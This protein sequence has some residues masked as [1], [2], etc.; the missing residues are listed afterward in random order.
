MTI[1]AA[2]IMTTP[3]ASVAPEATIAEV[4]S[5]L[6]S[7]RISAVPVCNPDG[8]MAG[9]VSES[10]ILKPFR[11]S[12][13]ARRDWWLGAVAE[14]EELHQDFLDYLRQDTRAAADVM[15]RH[16]IAVEEDATLPRLAELMIKHG[17]KRLPVLRDGRLV[18]IVSRSDLVAAVAKAPGMLV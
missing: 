10:D 3:V 4:A 5:L 8:S 7:K 6:A 1:T 16:V 12:A 11:E 14:G 18:G 13:R 9:I 2:E 17:V 15:V